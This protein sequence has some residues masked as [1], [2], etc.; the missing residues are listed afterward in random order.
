MSAN[1]DPRPENGCWWTDGRGGPAVWIQFKPDDPVGRHT[2]TLPTGTYNLQGSSVG[3]Y[4][5]DQIDEVTK[6]QWQD[7]VATLG[8][9]FGVIQWTTPE[10]RM[11][12]GGT[13]PI[14][15]CPERPHAHANGL[16]HAET[17]KCWICEQPTGSAYI[18]CCKTCGSRFRG[19]AQ[20]REDWP[21]YSHR[22]R[23]QNNRFVSGCACKSCEARS[24]EQAKG[25]IEAHKHAPLKAG[26]HPTCPICKQR[27]P[28][29]DFPANSR[30]CWPCYRDVMLNERRKEMNRIT[31]RYASDPV[32]QPAPDS[33]PS[34]LRDE[35]ALRENEAQRKLIVEVRKRLAQRRVWP[36]CECGKNKQV[37]EIRTQARMAPNVDRELVVVKL[38]CC[39]G[40]E[41]LAVEVD[42]KLTRPFEV[43]ICFDCLKVKP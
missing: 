24:D 3:G 20:P 38:A 18:R 11:D 19:D 9:K 25:I 8:N 15:P 13:E 10:A 30:A 39:A 31:E 12:A 42:E 27:K 32:I 5:V 1:T 17:G 14:E 29:C 2:V 6:R 7:F 41:L 16:W 33:R 26:T 35:A 43:G 36:V 28:S 40:H 37:V 21:A 22:I 34:F 23:H 4:A